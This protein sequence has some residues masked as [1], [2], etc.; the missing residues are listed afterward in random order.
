MNPFC[1]CG[2]GKVVNNRYV[3]GHNR[4]D[5]RHTEEARHKM[6]QSHTGVP[7]SDEHRNSLSIALTGKKKNFSEQ[8]RKN[9]ND[10][11]KKRIGILH[12][13]EHKNKISIALMG[14]NNPFYGKHHSIQTRKYLSEKHKSMEL[15]MTDANKKKRNSGLRPAKKGEYSHTLETRRKMS[16]ILK[17]R[18]QDPGYVM[19]QMK[20]RGVVPNKME[21][22]L[23][24]ILNVMFPG[25]WKY[26]GDG[27]VIISGKCPDFI[28]VN[29]R[30]KIVELFGNYW[31]TPEEAEDRKAIFKRFGYE[32]LIVWEHELKNEI[33]NVA[34]KLKEFTMTNL[35]K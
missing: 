9:I 22:I 8:G 31:H 23:Q 3:S 30:K 11:I 18:W 16:E 17:K 19:K 13:D 20:A 21:C 14:N 4:R 26:V 28:N 25:E 15:L 24:R 35:E 29:G 12:T 5:T 1:I 7:L 2:C 27:Q 10:A 6:R 33:G 34:L 32:T